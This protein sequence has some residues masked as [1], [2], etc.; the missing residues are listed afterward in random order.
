MRYAN[1]KFLIVTRYPLLH[2]QKCC[3]A[4][5]MP[6]LCLRSTLAFKP[7]R[8]TDL[9]RTYNGG[10]TELHRRQQESSRRISLKP[11]FSLG[12]GFGM[13]FTF[14]RVFQAYRTRRI[15]HEFMLIVMLLRPSVAYIHSLVLHI[16]ASLSLLQTTTNHKRV[17]LSSQAKSR[18]I[19]GNG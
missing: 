6:S 15:S 1:T 14:F 18:P 17:S 16:T 11:V 4:L 13:V 9:K 7:N 5:E 3:C 10:T 19:T 8:G 12:D 2:G